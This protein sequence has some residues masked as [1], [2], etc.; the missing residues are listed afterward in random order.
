MSLHTLNFVIVHPVLTG[1]WMKHAFL[2][3]RSSMWDL[4]CGNWWQE[5]EAMGPS[6]VSHL[7]THC[8]AGN[9]AACCFSGFRLIRLFVCVHDLCSSWKLNPI[10]F[11]NLLALCGN[12]MLHWP[13]INRTSQV[14]GLAGSSAVKYPPAVLETRLQPLCQEDPEEK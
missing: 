12:Q 11:P 13:P 7:L 4:G 14:F 8:W 10:N 1:C 3:L 5:A 2:V 9:V 6:P